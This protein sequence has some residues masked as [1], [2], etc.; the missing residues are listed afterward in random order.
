MDTFGPAARSVCGPGRYTAMMRAAFKNCLRHSV[1]KAVFRAA[2]YL[3]LWYSR[4]FFHPP[5]RRKTAIPAKEMPSRL[6]QKT[7]GNR[8]PVLAISF[9]VGGET[10]SEDFS[11]LEC[12]P[13]SGE[14]DEPG[15]GSGL[16]ESPGSGLEFGL[17]FGSSPG[18]GLESGLE[19]GS[20]SELEEEPEAALVKEAEAAA[21]FRMLPVSPVEMVL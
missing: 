9:S 3:F 14:E 17:E 13:D 8:S 19:P 2:R 7:R 20:G 10:G 21:F 15:S 16:D 12:G 5:V 6:S 4:I 1:P 18:S 11:G